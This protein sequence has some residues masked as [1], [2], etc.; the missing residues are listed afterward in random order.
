MIFKHVIKVIYK[1]INVYTI[2]FILSKLYI[3]SISHTETEGILYR[4]LIHHFCS[5]SKPRK[6]G[7]RIFN[8]YRAFGLNKIGLLV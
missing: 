5:M 4:Q 3:K 7:V 1:L 6:V 2:H 8:N